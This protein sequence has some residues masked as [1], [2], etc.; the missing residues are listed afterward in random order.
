MDDLIQKARQ[1]SGESQLGS[2]QQF[3]TIKFQGR[4]SQ[5]GEMGKYYKLEKKKDGDGLDS[6]L[7]GDSVKLTILKVRIR[8]DN[9]LDGDDQK[10][11]QEFDANFPGTPIMLKVG[12]GEW[13]QTMLSHAQEEHPDL[14][15]FQI[16]YVAYAGKLCKLKIGGGSLGNL[17]KYLQSIPAD[18]SVMRYFTE[19][20]SEVVKH[21]KGDYATMTFKRGEINP[22]F[23]KYIDLVQSIPMSRPLEYLPA[24]KSS[25][26]EEINI[27]NIPF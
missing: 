26:E 11:T 8:L 1:L 25:V 15:Y 19:M 27:E 21:P 5:Y 16:L 7:I 13:T 17:F 6:V 4:A 9:K 12:K 18:D 3:P 24:P 22:D 2:R 20:G 14:K 10:I 23:A